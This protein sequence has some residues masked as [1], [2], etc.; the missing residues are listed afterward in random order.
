MRRN[1]NR[2]IK[3]STTSLVSF[4]AIVQDRSG[5]LLWFALLA[6]KLPVQM[7]FEGGNID[8]LTGILALPAAYILAARKSYSFGAGIAFNI[9]GLLLLLNILIIAALSMPTP[10]RYFMNEPSNEIVS[11]FPY[12][13]LPG[14]LVPIAYGLNILS[15][16]QIYLIKK[17]RI[18]TGLIADTRLIFEANILDREEKNNGHTGQHKSQFGEPQTDKSY[19]G[20]YH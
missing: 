4:H 17:A 20:P 11:Q 14:I 16:R 3:N 18:T 13:L 8:V 2:N 12:I 19:S 7:S 6:G 1:R 5:L 10:I 9:T 15:L